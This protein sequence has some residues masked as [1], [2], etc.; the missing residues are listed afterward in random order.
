ML[1]FSLWLFSLLYVALQLGLVVMILVEL[2]VAERVSVMELLLG[3]DEAL[4][5]SL[6]NL[7]FC[8]VRDLRRRVRR[9]LVAVE[10]LICQPAPSWPR[11]ALLNC[12][13]GSLS[14]SF[15]R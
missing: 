10:V 7:G 6:L 2:L 13:L 3:S 15:K 4:L 9:F 1:L 12:G 11:M 8:L 5:L 14:W